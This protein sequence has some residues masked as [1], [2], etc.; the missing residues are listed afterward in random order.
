MLRRATHL[1]QRR[2]APLVMRH[3]PERPLCSAVSAAK[4]SL[5]RDLLV[6]KS[7]LFKK[8]DKDGNNWVDINDVRGTYNAKKHPDVVAGKKTEDQILQ[9]FL[10]TFLL[11][12]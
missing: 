5:I 4:A 3:G 6:N 11:P 7:A 10:Q 8:L 12:F 2:A 9:E 1:V